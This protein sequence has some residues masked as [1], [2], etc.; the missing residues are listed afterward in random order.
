MTKQSD[1]W[2]ETRKARMDE[3]FA[4][5][6]FRVVEEVKSDTP[7]QTPLGYKINSGYKLELVDGEQGEVA[8][9][10]VGKALLKQIAEDYNGVALPEPKRR[11]RPRKTAVEQAEQWAS[12]DIPDDAEQITQPGP[13]FINPNADEEA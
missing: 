11:G 2:H 4:G 7:L 10:Y 6:K 3:L 8:E 9:F 13:T 12:R 5:K 1:K